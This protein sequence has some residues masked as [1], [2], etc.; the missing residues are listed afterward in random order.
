MSAP[1]DLPLVLLSDRIGPLTGWETGIAER[2]GCRVEMRPLTTRE[3]I[4]RHAPGARVIILG[5][6]E[7]FDAAT[8]DRLDGL[9]LIVRRGVGVDNVDVTAA[10]ARGI[11]VSNVPDATVEEVSDHA[12]VLLT[13]LLRGVPAAHVAALAG[14]LAQAR[15]AVDRSR[16]LSDCV[17]AVLGAGRIGRRLVAKA[18]GLFGEVLVVDPFVESVEG[19]RVVG[20][21]EALAGADAVSVHA[22]LTPATRNLLDA[23]A[24]AAARPGL[25]VVNAARAEI[26]DEPALEHAV[27]AGRV[28][29]VGLDVT[30]G[31]DRWRRVIA[32]GHPNVLLTAHTGGRGSVAQQSL[33]R[34]CAEQVV[35]FLRGEELDTV[36]SPRHST[37]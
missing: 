21:A 7:P 16:P 28:A 5:A 14:Q 33:R 19:A 18:A 25:V 30:A 2:V 11:T 9:E 34:R 17:L 20:L 31:V 29:G 15:A 13:V 4:A 22:P 12:L 6:V 3:D 1:A 10:A 27:R 26:V 36:V 23:A 35:A 37:G 24:L 32:A 8:L